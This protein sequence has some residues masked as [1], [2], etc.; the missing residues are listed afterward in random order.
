MT[1]TPPERST[2][3]SRA[4][5]APRSAGSGLPAVLGTPA[6]AVLLAGAL[7]AVLLVIAEFSTL[8]R[9]HLTTSTAPVQSVSTGSHNAYA[10]L[11]IAGL[12]V[13]LLLAGRRQRSRPALAGLATLGVAA[14]LIALVGDLPDTRAHGIAQQL[15]LAS[16]SAGPGI[17]LETLG[18]VLLLLA[19]GLGLLLGG[20]GVRSRFARPNRLIRG[21]RSDTALRR[22]S[23]SGS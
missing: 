8:Y 16:T 6:A 12:A 4:P 9:V 22:E 3:Y 10:M 14:L 5:R 17:Y 19:G 15:V 1:A 21:P 20:P 11:P 2:E 18:A 23:R 13:A 7:G